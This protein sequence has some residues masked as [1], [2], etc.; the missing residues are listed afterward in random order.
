[1]V[2]DLLRGGVRRVT[3]PHEELLS[4]WG[5]TAPTRAE[6]VTPAGIDDLRGA[7]A[8]PGARGVVARGLGRAYGDAAQNAG[9][10]VLRTEAMAGV[11]DLDVAKGEVTVEAGLSLDA[12]M[13]TLVPLGWFPKIVPGTAHVSVGGAIA[14]D[15]HGKNHREGSFADHVVRFHLETP[16]LGTLTVDAEHE[17]DVFWAT[18][19]GMGLTGVVTEATLR[20]QPIETARMAVDVEKARDLDDLMRRMD[21][22]DDRYQY[23]VA[24]IDCLAR[25]RHLGRSVLTRGNHATAEQYRGAR[26]FESP[27]LVAAPPLFPNGLLNPLTI[28]LFNE[29]WFRKARPGRVIERMGTFFFPLDLVRGW[30]RVYGPRGFVQ[31]QFVV[32]YGAED[33]IRRSL[34]HLSEARCASFL[35]VLKRFDRAN[36]GHLSFPIPGWTL[37]LDVPAGRAGLADLLDRL[38]DDV[39][40]AGGR[41]YLAKD[42]R[43]RPE[44]IPI[45]YP[46]LDEWRDVRDALDPHGVLRSDLDRRL[47][48]TGRNR[49]R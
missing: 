39:V 28:R 24:W 14:A 17:P 12:L 1:V 25:G 22:G 2:G 9:G 44:L 47:D 10:R 20:L 16:G 27:S 21:E 23:V 31:Y 26:A 15:I 34:E 8:L 36:A 45:M 41:V 4:G 38:D 3:E 13:R 5:R 18:G 49:V 46:R 11:L 48:L 6:V 7:L 30:N 32:P 35:A 33:V 42:A 40:A 29:A 43:V 37:A 19:G